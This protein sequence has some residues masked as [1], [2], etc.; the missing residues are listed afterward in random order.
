[1]ESGD[2]SICIGMIVSIKS[3]EYEFSGFDSTYNY[4]FLHIELKLYMIG[5]FVSV[6]NS[7]SFP[8]IF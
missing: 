1:M 2:D 6:R 4:S 8:W 3:P 5:F 7:L